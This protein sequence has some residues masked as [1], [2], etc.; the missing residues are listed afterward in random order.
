MAWL[1]EVHVSSN[2]ERFLAGCFSCMLQGIFK[3][4]FKLKKLRD[5]IKEMGSEE[6]Q[7]F[8]LI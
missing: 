7:Y 3:S 6:L 8:V 2:L 4:F 1:L 5:Y